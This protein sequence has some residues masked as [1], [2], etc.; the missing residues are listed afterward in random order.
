MITRNA[1][2][3][4]RV[5]DA[6]GATSLVDGLRVEVWPLNDPQ[7]SV[8]ALVTRSGTYAFPNVPGLSRFEGEAADGASLWTSTRRY[9]VEIRDPEARF[10]STGFDAELPVK[11]LF[12]WPENLSPPQPSIQPG[13]PPA[14]LNGPVPLF[15]TPNRPVPASLAV[16]HAELREL[17]TE[18]PASWAILCASVGNANCGIGMADYQGRVSVIFPYP[19]RARPVLSSPPPAKNDF[20]WDV[21][22]SAYYVPVQTS[23]STSEIA[24]LTRT[25]KQLDSP[26]PLLAS[27]LP[28]MHELRPL[29][30]QYGIPLTVRTAETPDGPSSYLY[31]NP[32]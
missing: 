2:F 11:G 8:R 26:R 18:R 25:L 20:R 22:L 1:P 17:G 3:G 23:P 28:P 6:A 30:L 29:P 13:S 24:D 9:R 21:E 5:W 16:I 4:L 10:I 15:S 19:D 7:S 31:V 12:S 14:P 32:A 27:T